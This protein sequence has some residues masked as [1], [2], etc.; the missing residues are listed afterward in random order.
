[1]SRL[2]AA[3]RAGCPA[4]ALE[5]VEEPRAISMIA[6]AANQVGAA[7]YLWS[8]TRGLNFVRD[9][10]KLETVDQVDYAT[11][12]QKTE[13]MVDSVIIL[14]GFDPYWED[15][16]IIRLALDS[17]QLA[18]QSNV[19]YV[20]VTPKVNLPPP[21]SGGEVVTIK[22]DLPNRDDLDL[23][24]RATLKMNNA[25]IDDEKADGI[26][27]AALGLTC[28]EA[29][30]AFAICLS[31][32][33]L[34]A[35]AVAKEKGRSLG[36]VKGL[37][38]FDQRDL[39]LNQVGGLDALKAWLRQRRRAFSEEAQEY[40]LPSPKG[41]LMVGIPG[42]GKSLTA[43][44]V[45]GEWGLPLLKL[46]IGAIYGSLLGESEASLRRALATAE[47]ISPCVL[48][49][50]E[51]EKG[52][53]GVGGASTDSGTSQRIFGALLSW[54]QEREAPTFICATAN[55]VSALPPEFLR[56]GRF[57]EIFFLDLPNEKERTEILNVHLEKRHR[58]FDHFDTEAVIEATEGFVGAE[59]EQTIIDA[60]YL[61]FDQDR[62]LETDD[63][64]EVT[65]R[66]VPLSESMAEKIAALRKWGDE[67]A[68]RA[69]GGK[70]K[71]KTLDIGTAGRRMRR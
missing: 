59:I 44:A 37:E 22:L 15:P 52:F 47:A 45:A 6:D 49:V 26:I 40:G 38:Y 5:T 25:T 7:T 23:I 21:L 64:I 18:R 58:K 2:D 41:L 24:L 33:G 60:M 68:R 12:W 10:L 67:R 30:N 69:N 8:I 43:K 65:H 19:T 42:T 4:I 32:G 20:F 9:G 62:D 70:M 39:A 48:W 31:N 66:I 29:E 13:T 11:I 36:Q 53:S 28:A 46:D 55:D 17:F 56:R 35:Q 61:V 51:I 54:M 16:G 63:V 27:E 3:L 34:S 14:L 1:M 71:G 57:D 50:D